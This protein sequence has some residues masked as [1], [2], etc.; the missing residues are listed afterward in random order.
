MAS[1]TLWGIFSGEL[2]LSCLRIKT[3][4][5]L[6]GAGDAAQLVKLKLYVGSRASQDMDT[7]PH[8]YS[9]TLGIRKQEDYKLEIVCGYIAGLGYR[10]KNLSFRGKK[11]ALLSPFSD[12]QG[13]GSHLYP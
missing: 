10:Q 1:E 9:L 2:S 11:T 5:Q 12:A 13:K 4:P 8:T 3:K 7:E 6:F